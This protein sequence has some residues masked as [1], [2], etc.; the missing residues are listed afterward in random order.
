MIAARGHLAARFAGAPSTCAFETPFDKAFAAI[1]SSEPRWGH[2]HRTKGYSQ[3]NMLANF[4]LH[5]NPRGYAFHV[6]RSKPEAIG[7]LRRTNP[8]A[9][10]KPA[11][12][13]SLGGRR[14]VGGA[15]ADA[16]SEA[17]G[18]F[19]LPA[20]N[21]ADSQ[22]PPPAMRRLCCE[23]HPAALAHRPGCRASDDPGGGKTY[24][25]AGR[26]Y[27]REAGDACYRDFVDRAKAELEK[28]PV[29]EQRAAEDA[30]SRLVDRITDELTDGEQRASGRA[31]VLAAGLQV[32]LAMGMLL[33]PVSR[34][35]ASF[36]GGTGYKAVRRGTL[37]ISV[38]GGIDSGEWAEEKSK[39]R[40]AP[41]SSRDVMSRW[42]LLASCAGSM[43][44]WVYLRS[45]P[46]RREDRST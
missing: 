39:A 43:A 32:N 15:A 42:L 29:G 37:G 25:S 45:R 2:E 19:L 16:Y 24:G 22:P 27:R 33:A 21:A 40:E 38:A 44:A 18:G 11:D 28:A 3:F 10:F 9:V 6:V 12:A 31:W 4:A 20:A 14:S 30:C 8:T 34:I 46:K 41:E 26:C 5:H 23:L 1:T 17:G 7:E 35:L 36:S 13:A